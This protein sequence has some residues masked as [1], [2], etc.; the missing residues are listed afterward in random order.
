[1]RRHRLNHIELG[2]VKRAVRGQLIQLLEDRMDPLEAELLFR[3][4]YRM[5]NPRPGQPDYP[6][7]S[8]S[9]LRT[10]VQPESMVPLAQVEAI[11]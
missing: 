8:W 2:P 9:T 6:D 11:A 7:F 3:V 1:M 10:H 5:Q 4:W